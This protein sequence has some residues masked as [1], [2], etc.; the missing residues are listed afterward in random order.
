MVC[1]SELPVT[2][3][4]SGLENSKHIFPSGGGSCILHV[5]LRSNGPIRVDDETRYLTSHRGRLCKI[6]HKN[7]RKAEKS[8]YFTSLSTAEADMWSEIYWSL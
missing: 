1:L 5:L 2:L 7:M 3:Y 6:S 4:S 8:W